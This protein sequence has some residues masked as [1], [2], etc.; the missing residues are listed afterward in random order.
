MRRGL[1]LG[2]RTAGGNRCELCHFGHLRIFF[3]VTLLRPCINQ[4]RD[5][6]CGLALRFHCQS[7]AFVSRSWRWWRAWLRLGWTVGWRSVGAPDPAGSRT[8][9]GAGADQVVHPHT[10]DGGTLGVTVEHNDTNDTKALLTVRD[11]GPGVP[12]RDRDRDR[13]RIFG[14]LVRLDDARARD[15]GGAG[16]GLSIARAL[17]RAHGG[18]LTAFPVSPVSPVSPAAP[19]GSGCRC[20]GR[21]AGPR[22]ANSASSGYRSMLVVGADPDPVALRARKHAQTGLA[23]AVDAIGGGPTVPGCAVPR[24]RR[25]PVRRPPVRRPPVRRP[26]VRRPLVRRPLVRCLSTARSPRPCWGSPGT[27]RTTT[28]WPS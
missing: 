5:V 17:A 8:P 11:S 1:G 3:G 13:D 26:L 10:P 16:L 22:H 23:V 15:S 20:A 14:R 12:D 19:S 2:G 18:D 7:W 27:S 21:C 9:R 24:V 28:H 4:F 6:S 25:S